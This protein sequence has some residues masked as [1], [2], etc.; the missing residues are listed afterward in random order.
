MKMMRE[1]VKMANSI[2]GDIQFTA[3]VPSGNCDDKLPVLDLK[4]WVENR[5]SGEGREYE[6]IM[7]EFYEKEMVSPMM[8]VKS[9]VLPE[10]IKR[11]SL[12]Q[13]VIKRMRNS[14]ECIRE[15]R[16]PEIMTR[17]S[18]KLWKS[19]YCKKERKES[20]QKSLK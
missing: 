1:V 15:E 16:K 14:S 12:S 13:E 11:Q 6:E 19:G 4:M 8:I 20:K 5:K 10:K 18:Y 7:H 2:A 17:M 3:D 9:S